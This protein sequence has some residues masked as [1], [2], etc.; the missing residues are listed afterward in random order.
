MKAEI[1]APV[2]KAGLTCYHCHDECDR[3]PVMADD[4][5]FCCEGCRTVYEILQTNQLCDYYRIDTAAGV[6]MKSQPA[7]ARYEVLLD[8][9]VAARFLDYSD[10]QF[11]RV[12]FYLP[13]MHCS[14]CIWLLEHLYRIHPGIVDSRVNF[15]RR[16]VSVRFDKNQ[17][18]LAAVAQTLA[19]VGYA[20]EINMDQLYS[21]PRQALPVSPTHK[22]AVA[23]F[24]FGNV[25]LFSFPEY[26]GLARSGEAAL[27]QWF[28]Y[29]N[30]ALALPV[31]FYSASDYMTSAW[32]GLRQR[33][34]N[35]DIPL[36][37]GI[38]VLFVR[39]GWEILTGTG[40]GYADSMTGLVFFL[41]IGRWYQQKTYYNLSFERDYK[42]YF[43]LSVATRTE[44]AETYKPVHKLQPGD[45]ILIRNGEV[46]PADGL[47]KKGQAAIDYSFATG[48]S[49][50]Q[51]HEAGDT[52]YAGGR[53]CGEAIEL[54][55]LKKPDQS[56]LTQLW[57]EQAFQTD[58]KGKM[59]MLADQAGRRFTAIILLLSAGA[60]AYWLPRDI[61]T[62]I[63]A[64]SAILIVA[65]PCTIALSIPFTLGNI[66]R[67]LGKHQFYLKNT[68]VLEH[69]STISA[70]V[71]DKTG[72]ITDTTAMEVQYSGTPLSDRDTRLIRSL[73]FHSSHP[74][75]RQIWHW[76][77]GAA[78]DRLP[79][80]DFREE[81]GAGVA[82]RVA[83]HLVRIGL[84]DFVIGPQPAE[85]K[86]RK[87]TYL[88]IDERILG[89]IYFRNPYRKG[90][91]DIIRQFGQKWKTYLLSGDSDAE[92]PALATLFPAGEG[93]HF[94]QSPA[95]KLRF[96]EKLQTEGEKVLYIGDGLNDAGA[97]QQSEVGMV[98]SG[99]NNNFIP[100]CDV[101]LGA[102]RFQ[103]LPAFHQLAMTGVR[104]VQW[105]YIVAFAYNAVGL[106]FAL[107]GEI[108]PVIA[109]ILMP[110]SSVSIVLFGVL[111]GNI[112]AAKILPGKPESNTL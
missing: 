99:G 82:G 8:R 55:L 71:F 23:G 20:P 61:H 72:T 68:A 111:A 91:T 96:I 80:E 85:A 4:K 49:Q 19:K 109:A 32:Q 21:T 81:T 101:I 17:I 38:I 95:D 9:E 50:P 13:Q 44:G 26:L 77:G 78:S 6:S 52:L 31:F 112:A 35:I 33:H 90:C 103:E 97:L 67:L 47:L 57:N 94:R 110:L 93:L 45:T 10:E 11:A 66:L 87:G 36:A 60:L 25:M 3:H 39:T 92:K 18:S 16:E 106:S 7:L 27:G 79:V 5:A 108:S 37:L 24:C 74:V 40:A 30:L 98:V 43:P 63:N 102:D 41:L 69:L 46:V 48:E 100:A 62:A 65:C 107:S 73:A 42:S 64:C 105:S 14:S 70:A 53:Q 58:K 89:P 34:L 12:R 86:E 83:G 2:E 28:G 29:L 75:S 104:I 88:A 51:Y 22:I 56:Y 84:S 59:A 15:L 1:P 54:L 76:S